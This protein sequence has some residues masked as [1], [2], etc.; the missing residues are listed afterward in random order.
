M[1]SQLVK[2]D[3]KRKMRGSIKK[4]VK[5]IIVGVININ[6]HTISSFLIF[7]SKENYEVFNTS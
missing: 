2:L 4:R 6:N 1:P 7:I 3:T 5:R